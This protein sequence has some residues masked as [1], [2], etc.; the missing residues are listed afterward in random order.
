MHVDLRSGTRVGGDMCR[1]IVFL[2]SFRGV[3]IRYAEFL[4]LANEF[5]FMKRFPCHWNPKFLPCACGKRI[6]FVLLHGHQ[7]KLLMCQLYAIGGDSFSTDSAE[8]FHGST[9]G[10]DGI[11][12][13]VRKVNAR[14]FHSNCSIEEFH[15]CRTPPGRFAYPAESDEFLSS[16]NVY[17]LSEL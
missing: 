15:A 1:R 17:R 13:I 16:G 9:W 4:N 7:N 6:F 2:N 11:L 14:E 5:Y 8:L 10:F 12:Y 3:F